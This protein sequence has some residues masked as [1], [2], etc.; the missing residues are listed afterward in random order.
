M[1]MAKALDRVFHGFAYEDYFAADTA[2]KL[3]LILSAED[4]ILGLE[5]GKKRFINEVT[6]LSKAFAI[7]IPHEQAMDVKE[8]H[9]FV[10]IQC[11]QTRGIKACQPHISHNHQFKWVI[12]MF[13]PVVV[14]TSS[15]SDGPEISKHHTTKAQR[16]T[17]K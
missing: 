7:A 11:V 1:A 3:S 13:H 17:F 5:D 4:H 16:K 6:A 10:Y 15:S 14:M 2:Q 12:G 9:R 8:V